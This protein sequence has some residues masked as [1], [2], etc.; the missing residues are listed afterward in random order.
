MW[1]PVRCLKIER[2]HEIHGR[3]KVEIIFRKVKIE[4]LN[5]KA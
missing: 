2:T 5:F 1:S 4:Q 3:K